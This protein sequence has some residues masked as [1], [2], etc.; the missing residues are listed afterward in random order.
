MRAMAHDARL[1]QSSNPKVADAPTLRASWEQLRDAA[2]ARQTV[3]EAA[4]QALTAP[5]Y[6]SCIEYLREW[7]NEL[8]GRDGIGM[9][10]YAPLSNKEILAWRIN[11]GHDPSPDE[12]RALFRLDAV[13]RDPSLLD[14]RKAHTSLRAPKI[15]GASKWPAKKPPAGVQ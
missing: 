2:R 9:S 13:R 11:E 3:H 15:A 4:E 1:D 7:S 10:G 12:I 8:Y 14:D 6:P 5:E